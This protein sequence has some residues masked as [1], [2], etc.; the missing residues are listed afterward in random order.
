MWHGMG[1]VSAL[2]GDG[3]LMVEVCTGL[4]GFVA[5]LSELTTGGVDA[6]KTAPVFA[7]TSS[8]S[9]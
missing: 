7:A 3:V 1:G 8:H 9:C 6:S 4:P 2:P 5:M